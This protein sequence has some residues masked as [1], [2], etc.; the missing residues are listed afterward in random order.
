MRCL[1]DV[2][3]FFGALQPLHFVVRLHTQGS[4]EY[5]GGL[6]VEVPYLGGLIEVI[7]LVA[8]L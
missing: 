5:G 7:V 1:E 8:H 6:G 2:P 4:E 3:Y